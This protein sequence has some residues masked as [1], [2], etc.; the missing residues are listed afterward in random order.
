M[1]WLS[2]IIPCTAPIVTPLIALLSIILLVQVS[3]LSQY[4]PKRYS[5]ILICQMVA[6]ILIV[7][8][9]GSYRFSPL[10]TNVNPLA[11]GFDVT[12]GDKVKANIRSGEIITLGQASAAVIVPLTLPGDRVLCNWSS[13]MGSAFD[14][15]NSCET[16]YSPPVADYDILRL[17]IRSSCGLANAVGQI[18]ISVLP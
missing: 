4:H 5:L 18:K 8:W 13:Q 17:S 11:R 9:L 2:S 16:I 7:F 15:P 12:V 10:Y 6:L 1:N 14:D 3:F